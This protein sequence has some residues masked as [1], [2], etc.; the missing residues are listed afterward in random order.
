MIQELIS[1]IRE[2]F[3]RLIGV[4]SY[5]DYFFFLGL[6]IL[7]L[8]VFLFIDKVV[9]RL[10][11]KATR[12]T[13]IRADDYIISFLDSIGWFFYAYVSLYISAHILVLTPLIE[14][15]LFYVLVIF[16]GYY[17]GKGIAGIVDMIVKKKIK[18]KKEREELQNQSM[19]KVLG[20]FAKI[21]IWL[22]ILL[23]TLSNLGIEITPLVAGLGV[24]GIAIALALQTILGDLFNA[25]VIYFD[26]PFKEGDFIIVNG[27]LGVV[28][29][30][31][32]KSTRIKAL[33]GHEIVYSN[34]KLVS[35]V[36]NNYKKMET[37]RVAFKFGVTYNT[38]PKKLR[39]IKNIVT[40]I[41]EGINKNKK[42]KLQG[43]LRV[44]RV[45]FKSFGESSYDYEVEYYIPTSD[46]VKYMD[47]QEE[48]NLQM[49]ESF[50]K[51]K[52]E[53]AF[54]TRTIYIAKE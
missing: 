54:P 32:I 18:E 11:F 3:L 1:N 5:Q 39:K 26:K 38:D 28:K 14:K 29:N 41:L 49:T 40:D 20:L 44:G 51:E 50:A 35:S 13:K 27:D 2:S 42:I 21:G 45:H 6:F 43:K 9:F 37:R 53:F 4:N 24:G 31:G 10:I 36:I 8:L 48:I 22:L 25:F 34:T 7:F 23:L 52:V 15:I 19:I 12:R 46:Y 30:I 33:E 16:I 17:I 47:I